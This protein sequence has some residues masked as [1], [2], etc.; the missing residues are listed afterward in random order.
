PKFEVNVL[1]KGAEY[2]SCIELTLLES[3]HMPDIAPFDLFE[4]CNHS[5]FK[6]PP[7]PSLESA[8]KT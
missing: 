8:I 5:P 6:L 2:P 1:I 4:E 7:Y 3:N